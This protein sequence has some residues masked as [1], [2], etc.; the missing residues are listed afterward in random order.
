MTLTVCTGFGAA[1]VPAGVE[2]TV[3]APRDALRAEPD[4]AFGL[5]A[6]NLP[7][8]LWPLVLVM[9]QWTSTR[10]VRTIGDAFVAVH[11]AGHGLLVGS[12]VGSDPGT[13]RFL[14]HL[15][16]EWLALS[17]PAGAWIGART[18]RFAHHQRSAMLTL[19]ALTAAAFIETYAVPV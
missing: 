13:W 5:L 16:I 15:P 14:T 18:G 10:I 4:V 2:L 8:T 1:L 11:L 3:G 6:H 19:V 12:A 7:V 9:L 17:V